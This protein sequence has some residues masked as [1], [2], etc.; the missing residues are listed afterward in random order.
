MVDKPRIGVLEH[1]Y[2]VSIVPIF[3][4][5]FL[6]IWESRWKVEVSLL[7]LLF[8]SLRFWVTSSFNVAIPTLDSREALYRGL[9]CEE[10]QRPGVEGVGSRVGQAG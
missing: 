9:F 2:E 4:L 6:K 10:K 5:A 7:F 1:L 3:F 8:L